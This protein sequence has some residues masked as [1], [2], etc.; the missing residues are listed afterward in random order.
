MASDQRRAGLLLLAA[1]QESCVLTPR[2]GHV[3]ETTARKHF[4]WMPTMDCQIYLCLKHIL[5]SS[6]IYWHFSSEVNRVLKHNW[7]E[8]FGPSEHSP[9]LGPKWQ[10]VHNAWKTDFALAFLFLPSFYSP[11]HCFT[12]YFP[13]PFHLIGFSDLLTPRKIPS[14]F[15]TNRKIPYTL[16][17][18]IVFCHFILLRCCVEIHHQSQY[19]VCNQE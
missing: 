5:K 15:F 14:V 18:Q 6:W 13:S 12:R 8:D 1:H 19:K 3:C 7:A 16:F 9:T 2:Q 11:S 10:M 17:S 4:N